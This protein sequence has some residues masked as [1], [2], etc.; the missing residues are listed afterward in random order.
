MTMACSP[1]PPA[2]TTP[3][4]PIVSPP[5]TPQAEREPDGPIT[6]TFQMFAEEGSNRRAFSA[7]QTLRSG[8]RLSLAIAVDRPAF[9]YV[10]QFFPDGSA[11]VLFPRGAEDNRITGTTRVPPS[12]AFELD[13]VVGEETL[14]VVAST[15]PLAQVDASVM[16]AVDEVRT[17]NAPTTPKPSPTVAPA[18]SAV[19]TTTKP[20]RKPQKP[21]GAGGAGASSKPSIGTPPAPGRASLNTR[22]IVRVDEPA[23][24]TAQSDA[25]G[26]A[27]FHVSFQHAARQPK[28]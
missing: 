24:V 25:D 15:R 13:D 26:I 17:T 8:D 22:G 7:G 21:G 16:A 27:L 11:T 9:V 3:A 28:R 2:A 19:T 1:P 12:G 23:K 6:L 20:M 14:Y 10:L 18:P 5:P 4:A